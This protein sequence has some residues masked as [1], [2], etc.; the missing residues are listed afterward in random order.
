MAL[1][2]F[3]WFGVDLELIRGKSASISLQRVSK[4][5]AQGSFAT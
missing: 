5:F 1:L 2:L 4:A 3:G